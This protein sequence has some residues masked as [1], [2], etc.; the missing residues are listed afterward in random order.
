VWAGF[1]IGKR[2]ETRRV[3]LWWLAVPVLATVWTV[4]LAGRLSAR[5]ELSLGSIGLMAGIL[6]GVKYGAFP[7]VRLWEK[8]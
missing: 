6:T 4:D 5:P 1:A 7:E 2:F 8:R 3:M